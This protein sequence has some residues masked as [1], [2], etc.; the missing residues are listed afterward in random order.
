[1][2]LIRIHRS[3]HEYSF[4]LP[5]KISICSFFKNSPPRNETL[6]FY[7]SMKSLK[8]GDVMVNALFRELSNVRILFIEILKIGECSAQCRFSLL[9]TVVDIYK[10]ILYFIIINQNQH[11]GVCKSNKYIYCK[12]DYLFILKNIFNPYI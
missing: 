6:V 1:M 7:L 8:Y 4:L 3:I 2:N 11:N 9:Y 5:I 12:N 10:N